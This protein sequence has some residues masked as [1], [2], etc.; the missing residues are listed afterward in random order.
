MNAYVDP[1]IIATLYEASR[2]GVQIEPDHTWHVLSAP[3]TQRRGE[4]ITLSALWGA[5]EHSRIYLPTKT[6]SE[7]IYIGS[8]DWMPVTLIGRLRQLLSGK[9]QKY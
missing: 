9:N 5:F 3:R 4:N 6:R 1:Q 7:E 8:A 2:A